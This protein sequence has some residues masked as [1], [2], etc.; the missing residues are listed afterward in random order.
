MIENFEVVVVLVD[1]YS[2]IPHSQQFGTQDA[3]PKVEKSIKW[4]GSACQYDSEEFRDEVL[5]LSGLLQLHALLRY[6]TNHQ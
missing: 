3:E 1:K 4:R 6:D 5:D 2:T